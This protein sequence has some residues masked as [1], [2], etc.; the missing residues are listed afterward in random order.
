[1]WLDLV[2]HVRGI[3]LCSSPKMSIII[4]YLFPPRFE[5]VRETVGVLIVDGVWESNFFKAKSIS[6]IWFLKSC[7]WIWEGEEFGMEFITLLI[8]DNI[9]REIC[10]K[11]SINS[12]VSMWE[13][14]GRSTSNW[15]LQSSSGVSP[16]YDVTGGDSSATLFLF[17]EVYVVAPPSL[18]PRPDTVV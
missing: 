2:D 7:G 3:T 10:T 15:V 18:S 1:M 9:G 6:S 8:G 5:C 13:A 4:P 12:V 16:P 11:F 17:P 14:W